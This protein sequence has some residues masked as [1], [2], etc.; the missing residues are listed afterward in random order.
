MASPTYTYSATVVRIIDGD[1]AVVDLALGFWMIARLSCR[2][3][4]C[5]AI[6][7]HDAGGAAARSHLAELLPV[8]AEVVVESMSVDKYAGR[9]DGLITLP[10]GRD[11][12]TVMIADGY[13]AP[14]NGKGKAPTPTWPIPVG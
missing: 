11:A 1:T 7:L 12:T 2:L 4:G 9:F 14:W 8:G 5:N 3:Y 10:D 13:A 6:E